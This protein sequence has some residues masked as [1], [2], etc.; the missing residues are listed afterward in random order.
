MP[1]SAEQGSEGSPFCGEGPDQ[2]RRKTDCAWRHG[3]PHRPFVAK[4]HRGLGIKQIARG[5]TEVAPPPASVG[6]EIAVARPKKHQSHNASHALTSL[7]GNGLS[8]ENP[9]CVYGPERAKDG[10]VRA[11]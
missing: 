11:Y 5:D 8:T 3:Y 1:S 2:A 4:G 7:V 10:T 9:R 6:L